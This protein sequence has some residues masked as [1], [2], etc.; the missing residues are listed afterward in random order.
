MWTALERQNDLLRSPVSFFGRRK[1]RARGHA[2][3]SRNRSRFAGVYAQRCH[4]MHRLC[5]AA[6]ESFVA[7]E[8]DIPLKVVVFELSFDDI[9]EHEEELMTFYSHA[10]AM[11]LHLLY[12]VSCDTPGKPTPVQQ[13]LLRQFVERLLPWTDNV[14]VLPPLHP[15]WLGHDW[16]YKPFA[17]ALAQSKLQGTVFLFDFETL[18][19]LSKNHD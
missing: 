8:L 14:I 3:L 18:F 2:T 7:K 6:S 11:N 4:D 5:D 16:R 12:Q 1:F 13:N 15:S 17:K 9:K 10:T 19:W